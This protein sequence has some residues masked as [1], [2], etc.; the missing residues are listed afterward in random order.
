MLGLVWLEHLM[1]L[2]GITTNALTH[3]TD[4]DTFNLFGHPRVQ[5]PQSSAQ[6]KDSHFNEKLCY[7]VTMLSVI[8]GTMVET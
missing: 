5:G 3:L 1:K 7:N 6:V 8:H 2:E 4:A